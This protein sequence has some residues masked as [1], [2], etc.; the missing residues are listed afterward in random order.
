[1]A[2][3]DRRVRDVVW[4]RGLSSPV[5]LG[6]VEVG[7]TGHVAW[8]LY[9]ER[10]PCLREGLCRMITVVGRWS[11]VPQHPQ[12]NCLGGEVRHLR[13]IGEDR[14]KSSRTQ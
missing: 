14:M 9:V 3:L 11:C 2:F 6:E 12:S 5:E 4:A 10:D 13:R 1:M 7:G 8:S